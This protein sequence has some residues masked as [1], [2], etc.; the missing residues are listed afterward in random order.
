MEKHISVRSETSEL[1]TFIKSDGHEFLADEPVSYGGGDKGP[2]PYDFL[3][4]ALG[5]CTA[6]TI[7]LYAKRKEWPLNSVKVDL[8]Y[9][10]EYEKD[11]KDSDNPKAMIDMIRKTVTLE[12][13]LDEKQRQRI[14]DIADKCPVQKT[15]LGELRIESVLAKPDE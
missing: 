13:E 2:T 14:L 10:K 4:A 3:L 15:L 9:N 8:A 6:M 5:S 1:T 11:C 7:G 12:G